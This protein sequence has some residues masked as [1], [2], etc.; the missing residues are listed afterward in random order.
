M[1][2]KK[3]LRKPASRLTQSFWGRLVLQNPPK[4]FSKVSNP[5]KT[6]L[7]PP[8]RPCVRQV[9]L[10][11]CTGT[12]SGSCRQ[13]QRG[14]SEKASPADLRRLL[15]GFLGPADPRPHQTSVSFLG[16]KNWSFWRLFKSIISGRKWKDGCLWR[17]L[18]FVTFPLGWVK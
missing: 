1:T 7:P 16:K 17:L 5:P 12:W 3:S 15:A 8:P 10:S 11:S 6:T 2:K 4:V 13:I 18:E 9:L 14:W